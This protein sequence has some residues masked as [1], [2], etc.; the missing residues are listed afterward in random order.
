MF[1][2]IQL[3]K[4]FHSTNKKINKSIGV[5]VHIYLSKFCLAVNVKQLFCSFLMEQ[6]KSDCYGQDGMSHYSAGLLD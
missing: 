1:S 6:K 2:I 4:A 5:Y 3:H